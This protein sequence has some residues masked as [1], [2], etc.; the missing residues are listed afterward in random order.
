MVIDLRDLSV[1]VIRE[2][3]VQKNKEKF[4]QTAIVFLLSKSGMVM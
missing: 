1:R 3:R 2:I 4:Y